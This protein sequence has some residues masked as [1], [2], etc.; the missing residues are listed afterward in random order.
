MISTIFWERA[1]WMDDDPLPMDSISLT[2]TP[3]TDTEN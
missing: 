3:F 2:L 1:C